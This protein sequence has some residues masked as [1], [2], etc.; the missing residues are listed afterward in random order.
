ME[1]SNDII[2]EIEEFKSNFLELNKLGK[3]MLDFKK[4]LENEGKNIR[5]RYDEALQK[6]VYELEK[7]SNKVNELLND[8][9]GR[10]N[11]VSDNINSKSLSA[12]TE[13]SDSIDKEA[14]KVDEKLNTKIEEFMECIETIKFNVEETKT[15]VFD[16]QKYS[17]NLGEN[18]SN[19]ISSH[20]KTLYNN[21]YK[22]TN[23]MVTSLEQINNKI[24][25]ASNSLKKDIDEVPKQTKQVLKFI[26]ENVK[27]KLNDAFEPI[28]D[29][30]STLTRKLDKSVSEAIT[31]KYS[32]II[33]ILL[34][35]DLIIGIIAIVLALV[36]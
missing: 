22:S 6:C 4:V 11:E 10:F 9:E 30:T 3:L 17:E 18:L 8:L 5:E 24:I 36:K 35:F 16:A 34:T 14:Q 26:D 23:D 33:V 25:E 20:L 21:F 29:K 19:E 7:E 13:I 1:E 32:K 28:L 15:I 27:K 2:K 12:I 31:P